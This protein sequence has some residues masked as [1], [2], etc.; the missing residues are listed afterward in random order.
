MSRVSEAA[1]VEN[2]S[3]GGTKNDQSLKG[4][5]RV[6]IKK[7]ERSGLNYAAGFGSNNQSY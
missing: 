1:K 4:R 5:W 2:V 3:T 6:I 7:C